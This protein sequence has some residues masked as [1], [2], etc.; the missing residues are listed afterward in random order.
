MIVRS[1]G[2]WSKVTGDPVA[3]AY[4]ALS[5][6]IAADNGPAIDAAEAEYWR[7]EALSGH[8]AAERARMGPMTT[9]TMLPPYWRGIAPELRELAH[10]RIW[11]T[12]TAWGEA[13]TIEDCYQAMS[14]SKLL[15]TV[16]TAKITMGF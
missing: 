1:G 6:A 7:L 8:V 10:R 11:Y 3:D 2:A 5:A 15:P 16:D 13:D 12:R 14:A 9:G 4:A